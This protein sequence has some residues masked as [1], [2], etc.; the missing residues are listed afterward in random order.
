MFQPQ[1]NLLTVFLDRTSKPRR[2]KVFGTDFGITGSHGT[3]SKKDKGDVSLHLTST[4]EKNTKK[5]CMGG[6]LRKYK[7]EGCNILKSQLS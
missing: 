6:V 4:Q 1:R 3:N 7:R 5:V 2:A